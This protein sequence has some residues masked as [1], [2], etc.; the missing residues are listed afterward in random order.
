[1]LEE[2][3]GWWESKSDHSPRR[4]DREEKALAAL[5]LAVS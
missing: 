5:G 4:Y 3:A 2:Y 1:M